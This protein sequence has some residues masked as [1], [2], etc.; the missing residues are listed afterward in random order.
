MQQHFYFCYQMFFSIS[1]SSLA[2]VFRTAHNLLICWVVSYYKARLCIW[3]SHYAL[4][5]CDQ[6]Q[7]KPLFVFVVV[8]DV[9]VGCTQLTRPSHLRGQDALLMFLWP[10]SRGDRTFTISGRTL[11]SLTMFIG[12]SH[13]GVS[14]AAFPL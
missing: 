3:S 5:Q 6:V 14:H 12:F 7:R 8:P 13:R 4:W 9:S 11:T 1:K 10:G 2:H